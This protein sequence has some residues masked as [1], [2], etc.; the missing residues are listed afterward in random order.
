MNF[1]GLRE[2]EISASPSHT[3][4]EALDAACEFIVPLHVRSKM[5]IECAIHVL[6]D[7]DPKF[8]QVV[9]GGHRFEVILGGHRADYLGR[10][11]T[12]LLECHAF[13]LACHN[14]LTI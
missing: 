3:L 10:H 12:K 2:S 6:L 8:V 11:L 7:L 9:L 1:F 14:T 13:F 5:P 4:F